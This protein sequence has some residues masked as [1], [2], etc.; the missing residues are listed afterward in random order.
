MHGKRE[1]ARAGL[2]RGD[3]NSHV[4]FYDS[5]EVIQTSRLHKRTIASSTAIQISGQKSRTWAINIE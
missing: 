4:L 5:P 2:E 3:F 1:R